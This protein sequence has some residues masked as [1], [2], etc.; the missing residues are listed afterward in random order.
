MTE[1][2]IKEASAAHG[3][4]HL[5]RYWGARP[6][7]MKERLLADLASLDFTKLDELRSRLREPAKA[8]DFQDPVPAPYVPL[9][10]SESAASVKEMGEDLIRRGKTAVLTVA[11]GQG[12]RLGFDG[13]KG[14]FPISPIPKEDA[15][16]PSRGEAPCGAPVVRRA[17]SLAHH[18]QSVQQGAD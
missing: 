9:G 8:L 15:F 1:K 10:R 5:F 3:Q 16:R 2:Q 14:M 13:P 7:E 12:S 11:G 6:A 4:D 18:D 17:D